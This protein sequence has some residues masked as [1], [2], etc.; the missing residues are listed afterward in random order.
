MLPFFS[1][2]RLK[3][4]TQKTK[5]GT[6]TIE[7]DGTVVLDFVGDLHLI[8]ISSDSNTVIRNFLI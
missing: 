1:T 5:H 2:I 7:S 8:K 6:V 3:P 4:I